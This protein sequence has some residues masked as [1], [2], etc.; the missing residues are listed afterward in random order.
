MPDRLLP[1]VDKREDRR[2]EREDMAPLAD[3]E[4]VAVAVDREEL[5]D[6]VHQEDKAEEEDKVLMED[7]AEAEDRLAD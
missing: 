7:K 3:R 6:M 1:L 4:A 2:E 5:E